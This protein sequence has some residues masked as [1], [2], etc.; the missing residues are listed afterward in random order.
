MRERKQK[1]LWLAGT[2]ES[3]HVPQSW[4]ASLWVIPIRISDPR[5]LGLW[6]VKWAHESTHELTRIYRFIWST[7]IRMIL[8]HWSW[9]GSSQRNAPVADPRE[10]PGGPWPPL[11]LDQN[12]ARKA[13]KIFLRPFP[14]PP[15]LIWR[16]GSATAHHWIPDSTPRITDSRYW[17]PGSLG[18][19]IPLLGGKLK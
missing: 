4:G 16:S 19:C 10:G 18:Q 13:K 11:F 1:T 5:S 3:P 14:P 17:I 12:E 2:T 15:P 9:F 6:Q 8:D 7:M